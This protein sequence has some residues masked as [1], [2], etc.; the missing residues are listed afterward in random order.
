MICLPALADAKAGIKWAPLGVQILTASKSL[1]ARNFEKFVYGTPPN[2]ST[3][4]LALLSFSEKTA[5]RS[6]S[7]VALI[8][9]A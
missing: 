1:W 5:V 2:S 3:N 7:Q 6:A 4:L 9:A 8:A